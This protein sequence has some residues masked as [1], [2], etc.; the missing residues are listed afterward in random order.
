MSEDVKCIDSSIDEYIKG[1][2]ASAFVTGWVVIASIS[3]PEHD[4]GSEDGYVTITSEGL[5]HHSKLG[6]LT[7]ANQDL[8]S[9][10]IISAMSNIFTS[11]ADDEDGWDED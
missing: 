9:M 2:S 10:A 3:S 4:I 5:P 1:N 8:Q 11:R 7:M 6:L